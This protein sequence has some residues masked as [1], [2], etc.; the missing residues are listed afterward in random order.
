[1]AGDLRHRRAYYH[2]LFWITVIG[3]LLSLAGTWLLL[4]EPPGR[5]AGRLDLPGTVVLAGALVCLLLPLSQ[6]A[7][8]GWGSAA[9]IGL[10]PAP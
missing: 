2:V 9:V 7:T 6:A 4:S 8:W 3:G 5:A 1:V 10:R